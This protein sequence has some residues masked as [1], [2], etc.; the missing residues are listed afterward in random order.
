VATGKYPSPPARALNL[1]TKGKPTGVVQ[2][3]LLWILTD[4][5]QYVNEAGY[6]QLTPDQLEASLQKVR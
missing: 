6:I 4:G 5:Q 2:A 1:V 3:F